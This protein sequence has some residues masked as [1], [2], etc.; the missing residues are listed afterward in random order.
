[1]TKLNSSERA[2]V[3][4]VFRNGKIFV[5]LTK[6][7]KSFGLFYVMESRGYSTDYLQ[8]K[9]YYL[10]ALNQYGFVDISKPANGVSDKNPKDVLKFWQETPE[11]KVEIVDQVAFNL[12]IARKEREA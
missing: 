11:I 5:R 12:W 8:K 7:D 3:K 1:M 4:K 6:G 9:F 2:K 10:A